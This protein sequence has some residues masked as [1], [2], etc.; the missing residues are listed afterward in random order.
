MA[1][2]KEVIYSVLIVS[3]NDKFTDSVLSFLPDSGFGPKRAV[4]NVAMARRSLLD[5]DFDLITINTPLPDEFGGNF[6][7][8]VASDS[9]SGVLLFAN[10]DIYDELSA[11]TEEFGI[12]VLSKPTTKSEVKRSVSL[13]SATQSRIKKYEEKQQSFE[14]KIKEI[15]V[16]NHAK[17]LIIEHEAMNET[18]AHKYI[19]KQAMDRRLTR[20]RV[21]E[22][23][24]D[25]YEGSG[26]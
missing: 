7:I 15:R 14:D 11:K 1:M 8:D 9:N 4:R 22:E 10:S 3:A 21:A 19:E 17:W 12:L 23:I 25:T 5:R 13:L 2:Q 18:Q 24:I 20:L 16:I 26:K 6:A